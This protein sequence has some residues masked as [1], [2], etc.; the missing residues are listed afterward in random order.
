MNSPVFTNDNTK[1]LLALRTR[2]VNGIRS[3]FSG[4]Y[5][6][7]SCPV[8]GEHPD[9]LPNLLKCDI[10]RKYQQTAVM[11]NCDISYDDVFSEDIIKQKEVTEL[12]SE[13]LRIREDLIESTPFAITGP[14][15]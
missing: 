3:D 2:T 12:Y 8:C 15:H 10:I 5:T 1:L 6:T 9:T 4:M 13:L 7:L 11:S 14:V